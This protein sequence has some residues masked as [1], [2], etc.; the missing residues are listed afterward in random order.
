M[1][2]ET[3]TSKHVLYL[4]KVNELHCKVGIERLIYLRALN[5]HVIKLI[6]FSYFY[7]CYDQCRVISEH[8]IMYSLYA[9]LQIDE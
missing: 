1:H 5:K 9:M 6:S 8:N 2:R 3:G 7:P 4:P